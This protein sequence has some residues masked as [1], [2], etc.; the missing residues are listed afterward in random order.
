M[1]LRVKIG[2]LLVGALLV[3]GFLFGQPTTPGAN[4]SRGHK[5]YVPDYLKMQFAGNIGFVSFGTGY[6]WW[7]KKAQSDLI[8]GYVPHYHGNATIHTFTQKN[9]FRFLHF[10]NGFYHYS[11]YTGFSVSFEPGENSMV[12]LPDKYP[13]GYYSPNCFY[14]CLFVGNKLRFTLQDRYYFDSMETYLEINSVADYIFYNILA[15]ED[16]SSKIFSLAVGVTFFFPNP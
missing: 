15:D 5:W 12:T 4:A 7:K 2:I 3:P 9:S 1:G 11:L 8:Y 13:N 10:A 16:R 14:A 6:S